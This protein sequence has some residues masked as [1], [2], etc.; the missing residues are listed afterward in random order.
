MLE[1][2]GSDGTGFYRMHMSGYEYTETDA[3]TSKP[4]AMPTRAP[5]KAYVPSTAEV[6]ATL[7][8]KLDSKSKPGSIPSRN[9]LLNGGSRSRQGW[10]RD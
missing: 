7:E 2:H 9:L 5:T 3:P 8:F 10:S 1:N 4:T 6:G